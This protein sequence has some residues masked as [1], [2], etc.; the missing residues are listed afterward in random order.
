MPLFII[1]II[2]AQRNVINYGNWK[3]SL[4]KNAKTVRK[5]G[6]FSQVLNNKE[7]FFIWPGLKS[8][9]KYK[10]IYIKPSLQ[11]N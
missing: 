5:V 4:S 11:V 3:I 8:S 1:I 10:L 2:V 7:T 6:N 9:V